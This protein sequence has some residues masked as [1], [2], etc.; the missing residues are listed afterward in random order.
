M[1]KDYRKAALAKLR[2]P[3]VQRALVIVTGLVALA[4]G[5]GLG[6]PPKRQ[7]IAGCA[8]APSLADAGH[9]KILGRA[10]CR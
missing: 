4:L 5:L 2:C 9:A 10:G 3:W 6:S 7:D 8:K 1:L